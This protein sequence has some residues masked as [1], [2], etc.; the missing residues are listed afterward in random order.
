MS[1]IAESFADIAL[2]RCPGWHVD[3]QSS[4]PH[5]LPGTTDY[6]YWSQYALGGKGGLNS[7]CKR[8]MSEYGR[9]RTAKFAAERAQRKAANEAKV[10]V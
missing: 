5:T 10:A 3:G 8:C 1:D 6:F 2:K 7:M 4:A 9:A